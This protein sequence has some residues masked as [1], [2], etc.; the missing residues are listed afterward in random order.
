MSTTPQFR[1]IGAFCAAVR[2]VTLDP[3]AP[4]VRTMTSTTGSDGGFLVPTNVVETLTSTIFSRSYLLS[5]STTRSTTKHTYEGVLS[6]D[7]IPDANGGRFGGMGLPTV[8]ED[9]VIPFEWPKSRAVS[10]KMNKSTGIVPVTNEMLEDSGTEDYVDEVAPRVMTQMMERQIFAGL[11]V[12]EALGIMRSP[13]LVVQAI[14]ST[15]SIANTPQFIAANAAKMV[16]QALDLETA[17]FLLHPDILT[18]ALLATTNSNE[19]AIFT[20]PDADA[21][22]GRLATRPVFPNYHAPAVGTV[23]D[24]MLASMPNYLVVTKNAARK[25]MS[26]HARF[27]QDESLFRF[28]VRWNGAPMLGSSVTPSWSSTPKSHYVALAARS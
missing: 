12:G 20:P 1:S 4:Q 24:F 28:T 15:Q 2:T 11:G 27:L 10:L 13:S 21:P 19:R 6:D 16:A 8:A 5:R 9:G 22:F 7:S 26:V 3:T 18:A 23:G 14:E 17:I 25:A